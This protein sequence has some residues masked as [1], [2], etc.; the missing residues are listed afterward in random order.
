M[1]G[2]CI[3]GGSG[4]GF[5]GG[6]SE[7]GGGGEGGAGGGTLGGG[8]GCIAEQMQIS[9]DLEHGRSRPAWDTRRGREGVEQVE[10]GVWLHRRAAAGQ[11]RL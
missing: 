5:G 8:A 11:P 2:A 10:R 3:A 4:G 1:C 6:G 9:P 7:G